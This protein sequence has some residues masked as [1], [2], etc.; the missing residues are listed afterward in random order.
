MSIVT[1]DV[2]MSLDGFVA[3]PNVDV[4]RPMGDGG[5]RLHAWMS[6]AP[7]AADFAVLDEYLGTSGAVE[8][9]RRTFDVGKRPWGT[10]LRFPCR[11]L[12]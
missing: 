8:M 11:S 9:G 7:A 1:A 10:S 3:G 2:S 6:A 5:E 12:S 4:A